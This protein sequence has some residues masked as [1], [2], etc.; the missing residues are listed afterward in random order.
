MRQSFMSGRDTYITTEINKILTEGSGFLAA[1]ENAEVNPGYTKALNKMNPFYLNW[2]FDQNDVIS[3]TGRFLKMNDYILSVLKANQDLYR[4]QLIATTKNEGAPTANYGDYVGIPLG[5]TGNA[6]LEPLVSSVGPARILRSSSA[7]KGVAAAQA[8]PFMISSE[9]YFLLAEAAQRYNIAGLGS[10]Q[11]NYNTGVT[12]SFKI[13]A[14][15]SGA[16]NP[17][18]AAATYLATPFGDFAQASNKITKILTEKWIAL[19]HWDGGEAWAEYR[20]SGVPA[21]PLSLAATKPRPLRVYYPQ[22]EAIVNPN[23][24]EVNP[25]SDKIFWMP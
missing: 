15:L 5:G 11:T 14:R 4:L 9:V 20:K 1:G 23:Y 16:S 25:W 22:R 21:I 7:L 12:E 3:G 6:Y 24:V 2:G 18:G 8:T 10:A 19:C 17:S 13:L